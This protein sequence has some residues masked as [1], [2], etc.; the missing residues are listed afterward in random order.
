MSAAERPH[1]GVRAV[2]DVTS[3]LEPGD[4]GR[5]AARTP[6][7]RRLPA[8]RPPGTSA[9]PTRAARRDQQ[10]FPALLEFDFGAPKQFLRA[11]DIVS[12]RV[13]RHPLLETVRAIRYRG[14]S[15]GE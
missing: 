13:R 3:V 4:L 1:G 8:A 6:H 9:G 5:L 14:R 7:A 12:S 2:T 10:R 11:A 15:E